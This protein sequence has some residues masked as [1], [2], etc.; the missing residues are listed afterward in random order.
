MP[1]AKWMCLSVETHNSRGAAPGVNRSLCHYRQ[2]FLAEIARA[3]NGELDGIGSKEARGNSLNFVHGHRLDAG[4]CLISRDEFPVNELAHA[5]PI[6]PRFAY[7][8]S[9][10]EGVPW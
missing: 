5:A 4:H 10:A 3:H 8:P 2:Q 9:Q 1:L 6:R 7:S